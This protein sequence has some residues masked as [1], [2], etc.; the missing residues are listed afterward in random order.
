MG[1]FIDF[2]ISILKNMFCLKIKSYCRND[3]SDIKI[4]L[5]TSIC[6]NSVACNNVTKIKMN[7]LT[8]P[9]R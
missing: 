2:E 6:Y 8:Q 5:A 9:I 7:A 1:I 4:F 3:F